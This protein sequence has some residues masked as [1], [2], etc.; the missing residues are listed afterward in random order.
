MVLSSPRPQSGIA[1]VMEV[2]CLCLSMHVNYG[3]VRL[4][5]LSPGTRTVLGHAEEFATY[6]LN[7][8]E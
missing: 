3:T 6:F 2:G 4:C 1:P 5:Y 7:V 8:L